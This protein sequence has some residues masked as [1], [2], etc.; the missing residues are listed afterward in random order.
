MTLTSEIFMQWTTMPLRFF[1]F[2]LVI[3]MALK[4]IQVLD[5]NTEGKM[6]EASGKDKLKCTIFWN[7]KNG[8]KDR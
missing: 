7:M 8:G 6:I 2:H 1:V 3:A 4:K 5:L